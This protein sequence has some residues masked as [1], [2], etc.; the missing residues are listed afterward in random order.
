MRFV[1]FSNF[2]IKINILFII[3]CIFVAKFK[4]RQKNII[5]VPTELVFF[6]LNIFQYL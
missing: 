2:Y 3:L 6:N 4:L 1:L 5:F